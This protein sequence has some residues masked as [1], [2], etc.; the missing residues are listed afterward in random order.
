MTLKGK[1]MPH[2]NLHKIAKGPVLRAAINLGNGA[3]VQ[4]TDGVL[5]G[6]SPR[7]AQRL[8]DVLGLPLEP[9]IYNGARKVF[10]DS[11]RDI[12]DVAFLAIDPTRA[13]SITFTRPYVLIEGTYAV[14]AD[15]PL[16]EVAQAD[17]P[18]HK[19]LVA[20]GSAYDLYL[21]EALK[22][23]TILRADSPSASV[24]MFYNSEA[25]LV[26]GIRQSLESG[27][28]GDDSV[29]ILPGRFKSI[30]QA[31]ALPQAHAPHHAALDQF[32]AEAIV[33]GFVRKALDASGRANLSVPPQ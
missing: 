28:A 4:Q 9:V 6:V 7:L 11:G 22:H 17:H 31:M 29:R 24:E 30:E 26:A 3:L 27:F 25:T 18:D 33:E 20:R 16:T 1:I 8:A 19:I 14:R 13:Q 12:W 15:S 5:D 10:E 23:A 21:K 2:P 32:V